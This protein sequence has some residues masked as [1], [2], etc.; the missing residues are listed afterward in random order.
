MATTKAALKA[1]KSALDTQNWVEAANQANQV[2][3][4]DPKNYF[5][6]LKDSGL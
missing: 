5:G 2:V 3:T 6:Y 1:A 4:A